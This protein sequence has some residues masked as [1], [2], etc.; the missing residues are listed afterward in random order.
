MIGQ[1]AGEQQRFSIVQVFI[2]FYCLSNESLDRENSVKNEKKNDE[3]GNTTLKKSHLKLY[4]VL[5]HW[6]ETFCTIPVIYYAD[7]ALKV[8]RVELKFLSS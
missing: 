6:N 5:I 1:Q 8:L 2:L 3:N 7:G 4:H